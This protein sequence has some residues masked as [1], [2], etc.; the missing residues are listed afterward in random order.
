MTGRL[1]KTE[2]FRW[3]MMK[4]IVIEHSCSALGSIRLGESQTGFVSY[5]SLAFEAWESVGG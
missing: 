5:R 1:S 2:S 3:Q 4:G